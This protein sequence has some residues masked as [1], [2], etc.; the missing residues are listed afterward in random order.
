MKPSKCSQILFIAGN[1]FVSRRWYTGSYWGSYPT[2]IPL[3]LLT[4][5]SRE[6]TVTNGKPFFKVHHA[7]NNAYLGFRCPTSILLAISAEEE[8]SASLRRDAVNAKDK[9]DVDKARESLVRRYPRMPNPS[10]E[11]VLARAF[12]KRSTRGGRVGRLEIDEKIDL[13][14]MAYARH[15]HTTYET[16][17]RESGKS[18]QEARAAV[19]EDAKNVVMGWRVEG[20]ESELTKKVSRKR[21]QGKPGHRPRGGIGITAGGTV[22]VKS[23]MG[24]ERH[25]RPS[26]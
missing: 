5:D 22:K 4:V 10:V 19:W 15:T 7:V 23:S 13:A 21:K 17:M 24:R 12:E 14:V 26:D 18:R 25:Q 20:A 3:F 9:R 6:A 16:M 11:Q 8:A 1:V 2:A